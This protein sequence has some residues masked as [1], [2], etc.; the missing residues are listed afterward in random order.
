MPKRGF[1]NQHAKKYQ[2]VNLERLQHWILEGRLNGE[3]ITMTDLLDSRCI[4]KMEDG[5]KL[6]AEVSFYHDTPLPLFT[7]VYLFVILGSGRIQRSCQ[8]W[9]LSSLK[10]GYWSHWKSRWQCNLPLLQ[11]SGSQSF[12]TTR[13]MGVPISPKVCRASQ[14][15]RQAMVRWSKEP[16]LPCWPYSHWSC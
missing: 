15:K 16:R 4:H 5:V 3:N 7:L 6:L 8:H 10:K 12:D 14:G 1:V 9:G 2:P 11:H 13:Q